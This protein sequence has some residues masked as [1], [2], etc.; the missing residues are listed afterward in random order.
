[1]KSYL[2]DDGIEMVEVGPH[3]YVNRPAAEAL[4]LVK[5]RRIPDGEEN[6]F[7]AQVDGQAL[8]A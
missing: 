6:G 3:Q 2:R 8:P 7:V 5:K 1:M 4:H